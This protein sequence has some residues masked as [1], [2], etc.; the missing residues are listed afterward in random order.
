MI[1]MQKASGPAYPVDACEVVLVIRVH[2]QRGEGVTSDPIRHVAQYWSLSGKLL[3]DLDPEY[4]TPP[5]QEPR[6]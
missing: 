3:V 6:V 1:P 4:P 5:P 2:L